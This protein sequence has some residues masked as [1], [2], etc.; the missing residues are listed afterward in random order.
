[1]ASLRA[2]ELPGDALL[3]KYRGRRLRGLLRHRRR[4]PGIARRVRRGLLT[5]A[6][7][8][9]ERLILSWAV[10][11]PSTDLQAGSLPRRAG[12]VC[13]VER[14]GGMP[15]QLLTADLGGRT[16]SWLMSVAL[17]DGAATRLYFGSAVVP[18]VA[19]GS[20]EARMGAAFRALLGF[21]KVYSRVLLRA[22]ATRLARAR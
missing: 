3:R 14:R 21:H 2:C 6:V 9:L 7:F 1:M 5:T 19:P 15:R 13:R 17:E 4:S 16:R 11:R 10:A 22:A 8:R 20:G 18:V 12:R